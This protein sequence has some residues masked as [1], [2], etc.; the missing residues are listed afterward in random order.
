SARIDGKARKAAEEALSIHAYVDR[1]IANAGKPAADGHDL[2][3][4]IR[5]DALKAAAMLYK[6]HLAAHDAGLRTPGRV[7]PE[8]LR[9]R[10]QAS[11]ALIDLGRGIVGRHEIAE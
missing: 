10:V 1:K 9:L 7:S 11:L 8:I 4:G 2:S 6:D 5:D 3:A